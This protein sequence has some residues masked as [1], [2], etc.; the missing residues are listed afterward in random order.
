[1]HKRLPIRRP[2]AARIARQAGVVSVPVLI[3][4]ALLHRF[5]IIDTP[6][7]YSVLAAGF[8]LALVA[9]VAG[10]GA[11]AIL[12]HHGG[13]GASDAFRGVVVGLVALAPAVLAIVAIVLYPRLNDV[14]TDVDSPPSLL[15]PL[16]LADTR[17]SDF[18]RQQE[19][20]PD[21][22][23]RRFP[24]G[25]AELYAAVR[26]VADARGWT[27][28]REVAP[29]MNDDSGDL[30]VEARTLLIGF[31]DDMAIRI[32]R[33]PIGSRLDLR[34][35]SRYGLHDLG[36]NA[37]RIRSFLAS[38]DAVLTEAYGTLEP[39][40]SDAAPEEPEEPEKLEV[41]TPSIKPAPLLDFGPIEG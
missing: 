27:I 32:R 25:T 26:A 29:A 5:A 38:L 7:L 21:I 22:V 13:V 20:Y 1:M 8:G 28:V 30:W 40:E 4:G 36:A 15:R 2:A 35:A 11:L 41:P 9:V 37:R 34:S 39:P 19:A 23:P 16:G 6:A 17:V 33:D 31:T 24:I 3:I 18:A 12:W 14:S 10:A